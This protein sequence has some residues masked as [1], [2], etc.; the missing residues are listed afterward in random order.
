[1]AIQIFKLVAKKLD[2]EIEI[3]DKLEIENNYDIIV[4]DSDFIDDDFNKNKKYSKKLG[5]ISKDE[6]TFDKSKDFLIPRPFL[7]SQL[8]NIIKKQIEDLHNQK[9]NNY[10]D[11]D[12]NS[13][14]AEITPALDYIE[15]LAND[16]AKDIEFDRDS[17]DDE[18]IVKHERNQ[19]ESILD[20]NELSKI[21]DILNSST[22][23]IEYDDTS[24]L[25]DE[26]WLDL[27]QIIDNA[28]DE[29]KGFD[30][31]KNEVVNLILKEHNIENL[32]PL[33]NAVD[34]SIIDKLTRGEEVTMRIKLKED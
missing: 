34:Q 21:K 8:E 28:I 12:Y 24:E 15:T 7:P 11:D 16:V 26:D 30:F 5:A 13:E 4:I 3:K 2:L 20:K 33:F 17:E 22:K 1:M 31:G 23:N 6:L 14:I 19:G 10:N 29:M 32:K 27:S 18:S 9:S 25:S